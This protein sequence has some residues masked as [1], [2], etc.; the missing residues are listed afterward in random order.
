MS[1]T[2]PQ[3]CGSHCD[4]EPPTSECDGTTLVSYYRRIVCGLHYSHC[5]NGCVEDAPDAGDDK[6][7]RCL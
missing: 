1:T 4:L 2:E 6:H 7:A 5:A 3:E